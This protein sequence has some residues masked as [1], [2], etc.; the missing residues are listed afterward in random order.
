MRQENTCFIYKLFFF[1]VAFAISAGAIAAAPTPLSP[2][3]S[4]GEKIFNDSNLSE[5]RGTACVSCHQ[6]KTGF[7]NLN[8]SKIGVPRGSLPKSFG[9]RN[10]MQNSYASFQP[11]FGFRVNGNDVDPIGGLFWDG[12]ADT[13]AQQAQL[14]FLSAQEMNNKDAA[15]VIAKI[16]ASPYAQQ[17]TAI[18]GKGVFNNPTTA[19]AHVGEAIAAF[20]VSA[21]FESFSSRYDAFIR[22]KALFTPAEANGMKLFMDPAKGNCASCHLMNPKSTTARDNLFTDHGHYATGI[23]RNPAI[24]A[25]ANPSYFDLGLCGPQ[26]TRPALTPN[27]PTTITVEKFCGTFQMPSLRNVAIRQ[28]FMHNGFFDNLRDVV[29]FYSTRNSNPKRWYGPSGIPNDLPVAYLPN[30]VNDRSPFDRPASA[31]PALTEKEI[32]DIVAF[33]HTLTDELTSGAKETTPLA[34]ASLGIGLNPFLSTA[35]PIK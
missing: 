25:N 1:T 19:M 24:P 10:V 20:E 9:I 2:L 5:P 3:A 16:A 30:I 33:L 11:P 8:S 7:S 21:V 22:G 23:P 28:V 26:R 17:M 12:R 32:D 14:P 6:A 18:F 27:V 29:S 4:L 31:G 34:P 13:L 15:S 35:I